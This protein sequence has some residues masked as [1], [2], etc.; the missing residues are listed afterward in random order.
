MNTKL[1]DCLAGKTASYIRPFLWYTG[2][3]R[4]TI[5]SELDAMLAAGIHEF[6][7]ENRGCNVFCTEPWFDLFGFILEAAKKRGMGVWMLDDSNVPTG[8]ANGAIKREENKDLRIKCLRTVAIDVPGP[9]DGALYLPAHTE[10]EKVFSVSAFRRKDR[11][12]ILLPE[13][14]ELTE[15]VKDDLCLLELPDGAWRVVFVFTVDS[16]KQGFYANYVSM[17]SKASCHKIIEEVHEKIYARFAQY[18]GNTFRG[19]FSDE[20]G[21]G[22]NDGQYSLAN[23]QQ[24]LGNNAYFALWGGELPELLAKKMAMPLEECVKYLPSLWFDVEGYSAKLRLAYMDSA[25]ELWKE[26]FSCQLGSW[27]EAHNVLY[28]GHNLEDAGMHSRMGWGCGH[29]FRSMDGQSMSGIDIVL[30]QMTPGLADMPQFA[31]ATAGRLEKNSA[32]YHYTLGKLGASHAHINPKMQNRALCEVFGGY[33][34]TCGLSSMKRIFNY[35]L[36]RGINNY[37]PHAFSMMAPSVFNKAEARNLSV[38]ELPPGYEPF[39]LP[40]NFNARG[41]NPQYAY[42]GS[43]IGYVQRCCHL[44]SQGVHKPDVAVYYNAEVDWINYGVKQDLD[45]VAKELTCKGFDFDFVPEDALDRLVVENN[46]FKVNQETWGAM[47]VPR[48]DY[49]PDKLFRY[50]KKLGA[51]GVPVIFVDSYPIKLISGAGF[52][53]FAGCKVA[54]L[55]DLANA[56]EESCGRVLKIDGFSEDLRY[57]GLDCGASDVY[58]FHNEGR[59]TLECFVNA[60]RRGGCVIYDPW[61]NVQ[62]ATEKST[63]NGVKLHLQPGRM[64]VLAFGEDTEATEIYSAVAPVVEDIDV[65][66]DIYMRKADEKDFVLLKSKSMAVSLN[67]LTNSTRLCAEFRYEGTI[68]CSRPNARYLRIP[69]CGDCA[70]IWINGEN[71][72][73][74]LGPDCWF[75]VAGKFT[76]GRNSIV[77]KTADNP[78]Y[79]D[80]DPKGS[81]RWGMCLPLMIHGFQGKIQLGF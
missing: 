23:L 73:V 53:P 32:F 40:P 30:D 66:W 38:D 28:I 64:L 61:L 34:W 13:I 58:F 71:C 41:Y 3:S 44:L 29:F 68:E 10:V 50:L 25:T 54:R 47:L 27:C 51:A 72:G 9:A 55:E 24:Q 65:L 31:G 69:T 5:E 67:N 59:R 62:Y 22:N 70:E 17:V 35:M 63:K 36:C 60:T 74:A 56:I 14:I 52:K 48:A 12:G 57:Y 20:P 7:Y 76:K 2:E 6:T 16:A 45:E 80:R 26:N 39:F 75:N 15:K 11:D 4:E 33:G 43:L 46:R 21:F 81:A 77:I 1:K 49:L 42:F 78:S 19:F 79:V 37:V 8:Y 18:F